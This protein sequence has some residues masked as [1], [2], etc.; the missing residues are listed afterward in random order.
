MPVYPASHSDAPVKWEHL[1]DQTRNGVFEH[2]LWTGPAD[3][4]ALPTVVAPSPAGSLRREDDV[5]FEREDADYGGAGD[6]G[7]TKT[8]F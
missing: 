8:P 5:Y 6:G 1:G 2:E 3:D 7:D 4:A